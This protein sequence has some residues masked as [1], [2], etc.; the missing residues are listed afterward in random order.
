M[1]YLVTIGTR[2]S[3]DHVEMLLGRHQLLGVRRSSNSS[4]RTLF[5]QE[6]QLFEVTLGQCSCDLVSAGA[7]PSVEERIARLRARYEGGVGRRRRLPVPWVI[8]GWRTNR[9]SKHALNRRSSCW[10]SCKASHR[11]PVVFVCSCTITRGSSTTRRC[12][13]AGRSRLLLIDSS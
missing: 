7:E 8:G 2:E 10:R 1:C 12:E 5:P 4:L 11:G 3:R 9:K 13:R 6:D